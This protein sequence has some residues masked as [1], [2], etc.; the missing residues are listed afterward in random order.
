MVSAGHC[1]GSMCDSS[2]SEVH[3][4]RHGAVCLHVYGVCESEGEKV[5]VESRKYPLL[6]VRIHL[7]LG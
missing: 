2:G 3:P 4:C 1:K 5:T 6:W 7:E